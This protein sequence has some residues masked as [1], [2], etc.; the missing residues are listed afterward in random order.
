MPGFHE[1]GPLLHYVSQ[2]MSK[3][4]PTA[5]RRWGILPCPKDN[6]LAEGIGE[7]SD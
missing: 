6:V 2:F 3:K 4:V 1:A 5:L 7:C